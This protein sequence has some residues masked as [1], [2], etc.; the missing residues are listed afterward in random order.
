[1][2]GAAHR[3][4]HPTAEHVKE[5]AMTKSTLLVAALACCAGI[6][7]AGYIVDTGPGQSPLPGAPSLISAGVSY[8]HFGATFTVAEP[9]TITSVEG[10]IGT[11]LGQVVMELHD[12]PTPNDTL[13]Y[14]ATVTITDPANG[15]RGATALV[16]PV[17]P[18]DYTIA[19]IAQPGFSG[20]MVPAPPQPLGT[21][22]FSNPFNP[23]WS[24]TTYDLGWRVGAVPLDTDADGTPDAQDNC[25]TVANPT[26]LDADGDGYGNLCDPDF[27]NDGGVN[28]NDF[29]RLKA[30]LGITPVTD[31][32][33]D[34]DG[35]AAVNINDLNRLKSYLGKPPG[36]SGLHPNCPPVCP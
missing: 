27:N 28:I 10:W 2:R 14:S 8:Q 12:G 15:W 32:V 24:M 18:G 34:L 17:A 23:N 30:R 29:N 19:V 4:D 36:P 3:V 16:W 7:Q 22:W 1:V 25:V 33:T 26:Q 13:L 35:N 6:A 20:S 9:S 31:T 11:G 21:E 5:Q